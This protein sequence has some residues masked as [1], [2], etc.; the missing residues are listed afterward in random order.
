MRR[1]TQ[2][3]GL[4]GDSGFSNAAASSTEM[5]SAGSGPISPVDAR[6]ERAGDATTREMTRGRRSGGGGGGGGGA[7]G[8]GGGG[9]LNGSLPSPLTVRAPS[10]KTMAA[11]EYSGKGGAEWSIGVKDD[12]KPSLLTGITRHNRS[13][14]GPFSLSVADLD[15]FNQP[16]AQAENLEALC[17]LGGTSALCHALRTDPFRGPWS[18]MGTKGGRGRGGGGGSERQG[19]EEGGGRVKEGEGVTRDKRREVFGSNCLPAPPSKSFLSLVWEAVQDTTL[20]ILIVAAIVS[21]AIGLWQHPEQGWIEGAAILAAVVLV[22]LITASNDYGKELKFRELQRKGEVMT[23]KILRSVQ[24]K[25]NDDDDNEGAEEEKRGQVAG[26]GEGGRRRNQQSSGVNEEEEEEEEQGETIEVPLEDVVVGDVIYVR[27]G[28]KIP[29]DGV[30]LRGTSPLLDEAP[31]TGESDL[32]RKNA[33]T[34]AMCAGA[35]GYENM[36]GTTTKMKEEKK[37]EK[38]KVDPFLISGT[39]VSEGDCYFVAIA[40]GRHSQWGKARARLQ[41]EETLTPLQVRTPSCE[42]RLLVGLFCYVF[43]PSFSFSF[44]FLFF[45]PGAH[46]CPSLLPSFPPSLFSIS[47][48]SLLLFFLF[49]KTGASG[50]NGQ[51]DRVHW[52]R[53]CG[54]HVCCY[55]CH[56]LCSSKCKE[57]RKRKR[58]RKRR[59]REGVEDD[60]M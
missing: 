6:G 43:P 27:E 49:L 15:A 31:L 40:V 1:Q 42:M 10:R 33:V 7:G 32:K 53:C 60:E 9:G 46:V 48:A 8:G 26:G 2:Q 39:A 19:E 3:I 55:G 14:D 22:V 20:I 28:D 30:Y 13:S 36:P 18:V 41:Q 51:V 21:L 56:V 16:Q 50:D 17:R 5:G 34:T 59:G 47:V 37:G 54:C 45:L 11:P 23:V 12:V 44:S 38:K 25:R 58:E 4:R 29:C 52:F 24:G 35:R 57:K